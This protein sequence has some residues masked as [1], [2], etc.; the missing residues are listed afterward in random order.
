MFANTKLA[1]SIQLAI[2]FGAVSGLSLSTAAVA[3][4]TEEAEANVVEKIQVTGS[5][6]KRADMEGALP[7]TVI[8]RAAI[9]FSGQTSVADLLRNTSFNSTGSFR[10]QS[11]SSAQGVSQIN[12][13]GLG[14][15]RSLVLVDGRRL[16]RSP[17]TGAT[18]DLNGIPAAAVERIEILTD[19]ASAVYGSDAIGGVVNIITRK[20]FTGVELKLGAAQVDVEGGDREEGSIIFG[21]S[22]DKGSM[23]GGVSWNSR[24][25]IFARAFDWYTPG[26]SFYSQNFYDTNN[27]DAYWTSVGPD[28]CDQGEFYSIPYSLSVPNSDGVA[29]RC[30]FNFASVSADEAS[31]GNVGFFLNSRYEIND[32]WSIFSNMNISKSSSFGR[33]APSL[34][35]AY[36]GPT[37]PNNPTNPDSPYY[38]AAWNQSTYDATADA[39]TGSDGVYV[40]HRFAGLGNRD[41]DVDNYLSDLLVAVEGDIDGV[42]VEFGVRRNKSRTYDIGRNY[43]VIPIAEQ[44]MDDG[45][46]LLGD[47]DRNPADVLNSMKATISRIGDYNQDEVFGSVQFDL[48]DM[49]GGTAV[50]IVGGEWRDIFYNDQYDSLSE[51]GVIGG[52][53][54]NSAGGTRQVKAA[55]VE[56]VFPVQDNLEITTAA[57]YDSYNDYGSD[58]SPKVS[59]RYNP[60]DELVLRASYGEGFRAPSLDILTQKESFSADSIRDPQHCEAVG[61]AATCSDQV[62]AYVIAN[63]FLESETSTQFALGMAY[64]AAEWID[65]SLDY[66]NIEIDN[67]IKAFSAGELVNLQN[68]GQS[69]PAGM[70]VTRLSNGAIDSITRGYGNQGTL[71]TSGLDLNLNTRFDFNEMGALRSNLSMSYTEKYDV[72]GAD[73]LDFSAFPAYRGVLSNVYSIGDFDLAWNMNIIGDTA[74]LSGAEYLPVSTWIT[75][76]VNVSYN[77]PWGGKVTVGSNNIGG[78]API[79]G[80]DPDGSREYNFSLYDGYGRIVY[81]RY[82]QSF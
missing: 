82:T 51:G 16:A 79:L 31:T 6:I 80:T 43:V 76:D 59:V 46:Y 38:D 62:D 13:R 32:D 30:G 53:A 66:F 72:D 44:Y 10:P 77:A 34:A 20:D 8:D 26:G 4:E 60:T 65:F 48:F 25:I 36:V 23:L 39:T 41:N 67:R 73:Q 68:T 12:L 17:S 63:P 3:Q 1:K 15:S 71:E 55:Y 19:G 24:D 40:L 11:G 9:E 45:S 74:R 70:Q 22:G 52:S 21:A 7:V 27:A 75:N 57:R 50:A 49:D 33:Y 64:E 81:A 61:L 29:Q 42:L 37:S 35:Q 28:A 58:V 54:G 2:A 78:K 47:L 5:R 14:A 56:A 69:L 18:Q